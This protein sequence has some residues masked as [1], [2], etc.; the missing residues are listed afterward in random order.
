MMIQEKIKLVIWDLDETLWEGVLS[1]DSVSFR[2]EKKQIITTLADRGIMNSICSKN[3]FNETKAYLQ[4]KGIWNYFIFPRISWQP[5]GKMIREIIN[6]CQF[7][8]QNVLFIDDN[9]LNLEEAKFYNKELNIKKPS[10]ID[11]ILSHPKLQGKDDPDHSRLNHYKILEDKHQSRSEYSDNLD[12]LKECDIQATIISSC[13]PH[14]DRIHE[15]IQRT[16]QLNYTKKRITKSRLQEIIHDGRYNCGCIRVEDKFGH[17]GIVGF[18]AL[19]K[20]KLEHF[21]FS[22]RILNLGVVQAVYKWLDEPEVNVKPSVSEELTL[23]ETPDWIEIK[24]KSHWE[25]NS[26]QEAQNEGVDK[27]NILLKGGCDLKQIVHYLT[28][29]NIDVRTE[30]NYPSEQG[31]IIHNEHTEILK[32]ID[33]L[34]REEKAYLIDKLPFYDGK[35]FDTEMFS[36]NLDIVIY[37]VLMDY[38]QGVYVHKENKD[39]KV[40]YGDFEGPITS[41][42]IGFKYNDRVEAKEFRNYFTQ[43]FDFLGCLSENEFYENLRWLRGKLHPETYLIFLNGSEVEFEG[44]TPK[45]RFL[46][47]KK[48]NTVLREFVNESHKTRLIDVNEFLSGQKDLRDSELHYTRPVYKKISE[49]LTRQVNEVCDTEEQ[50]T[51]N[52]YYFWRRLKNSMRNRLKKAKRKRSN[53]S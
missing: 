16:N 45:N 12:F 30:F 32:S 35:V 52:V 37:S 48:M 3:D 11:E 44:N 14:A 26:P 7:R 13:N 53:R 41:G 9:H 17:Y 19:R 24:N 49:E 38:T 33:N 2:P 42:N 47:H 31:G 46:H 51:N 8:P 28:Y 1:E 15:L 5:K 6:L 36:S 18:Y 43:H 40:T 50:V 27:A 29:N 23:F 10:F 22:C 4:N 34:S 39:L 20:N 21:V 25:N